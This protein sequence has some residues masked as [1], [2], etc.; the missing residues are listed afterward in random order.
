AAGIAAVGVVVDRLGLG[1]GDFHL[2]GVQH[3]DEIAGV[4]V[5]GIRG[6]VLA[7]KN[8]CEASGQTTK[9][10]VRGIDDK[11]IARNLARL[12]RI[13]AHVQPQMQRNLKTK[14]PSR[15]G[16]SA[17]K[18]AGSVA[19]DPFPSSLAENCENGDGTSV[20]YAPTGDV[21]ALRDCRADGL[22]RADRRLA[23]G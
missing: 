4:N 18:E 19:I 10:L 7:L 12:G 11:P 22:Y 14:R 23:A 21:L 5:G 9:D 15:R 1:A 13:G 16:Q 17:A 6:L 3:D 8:D 2:F 20:V